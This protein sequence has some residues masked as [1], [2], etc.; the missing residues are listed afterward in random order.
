MGLLSP[1]PYTVFCPKPSAC[2]VPPKSGTSRTQA[3]ASRAMP[4][5]SLP[6][7]SRFVFIIRGQH[8]GLSLLQ[9]VSFDDNVVYPCMNL[10]RG[11][12]PPF[13]A[14]KTLKPEHENPKP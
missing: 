12:D 6:S 14:R 13:K 11:L 9:M 2:F 1:K 4:S 5:R 7:R 3:C 10:G 8:G